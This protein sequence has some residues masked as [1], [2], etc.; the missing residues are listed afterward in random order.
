MPLRRLE[1]ETT[2]TFY[3]TDGVTPGIRRDVVPAVVLVCDEC[4]ALE[5]YNP[6]LLEAFLRRM[7]LLDTER[8]E[9]VEAIDVEVEGG[10]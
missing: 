6:T 10:P 3:L 8:P 7:A 2:D 9:P 5:L 1:G 4:G